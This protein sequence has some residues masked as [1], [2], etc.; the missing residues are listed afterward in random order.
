MLEEG[1]AG[2]AVPHCHVGTTPR[3]L[4]MHGNSLHLNFCTC[5]MDGCKL[6]EPTALEALATYQRRLERMGLKAPSPCLG[7]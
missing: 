4:Q 7:L 5:T 6:Q 1:I 2:A 3:F